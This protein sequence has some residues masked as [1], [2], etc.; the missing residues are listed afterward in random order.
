MRRRV[1]RV[2]PVLDLSGGRAV[3]ARGGRRETYAPVRSRLAPGEGDALALARAYRNVLRCDECYVAD[4]D[5]IA[6]GAPQLELLA[7]I[8][9]LGGRL[10]VDAGCSTAERAREIL[11]AG[12]A[13][14]VV[15]LETLRSFEALAA[16][17]VA[18]GAERVVFS[19]DLRDGK[20]VTRLGASSIGTPPA[21]VD[22]ACRAGVREVLLLDVARAGVGGGVD[23]RLVR[24]IRSLHQNAELLA[25]G[26]L[27]SVLEIERAAGAGLDGVLVASALHDGRLGAGELEAVRRRGMGAPRRGGHANDSR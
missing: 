1:V 3:H 17:G 21:L 20:P 14:V 22:K 19:L 25:G 15:G 9:R 24:T 8:A 4:L 18:V 5:A 2:I 16:I 10:L 13:R 11:T 7:A 6:G 27:G 12:A 26:G 23:L